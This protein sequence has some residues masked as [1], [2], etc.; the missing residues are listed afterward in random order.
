MEKYEKREIT[1]SKK[2]LIERVCDRCKEKISNL[3]SYYNVT[4][5]HYDWG[6]DSIDSIER[7]H[8]CSCKCLELE[9]KDYLGNSDDT[10]YINIEKV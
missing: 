7:L 10:C 2:V 9:M 5:G 1:I 6:R 3:D 4:T 8:I